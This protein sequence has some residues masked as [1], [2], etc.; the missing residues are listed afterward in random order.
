MYVIDLLDS[1]EM[2]HTECCALRLAGPISAYGA[3]AVPGHLEPGN[4]V[5]CVW[6]GRNQ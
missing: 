4:T 1:R 6:D 3:L 5:H 2:P